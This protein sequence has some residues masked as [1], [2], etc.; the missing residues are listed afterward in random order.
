MQASKEFSKEQ[1]WEKRI[2]FKKTPK[3]T[4]KL[5]SDEKKTINDMS[6]KPLDGIL[7]KVELDG[8]PKEIFTTAQSL[9]QQLSDYEAGQTVVIELK[10]IKT[11][12]GYRSTFKVR[13][14]E[15]PE[16]PEEEEIN[17]AEIPF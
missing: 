4:V 10:R 13:S 2:S 17:V 16:E 14:T 9:I 15:E 11:K 3:L 1:G 8:E 12:D 6:G 7:I 5:V